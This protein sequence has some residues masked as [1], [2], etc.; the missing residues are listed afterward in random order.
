[1]E[2]DELIKQCKRFFNC[3]TIFDCQDLLN[4][5]IEFFFQAVL[6]HHDENVYSRENADAKILIQMMMTKALHLKNVL[7]GVDYVSQDGRVLNNIIDP[8]IVASLIRNVYET[9]GMFNL[10]YRNTSNKDEKHIL[11]LLWVHAGL[12]YRQL[13]DEIITTEENRKKS[14]DEKK[15]MESIQAEIEKKPLFMKLDDKNKGK[16]KTKIKKRDYLLRFENE[17]V[18]FLNWREL[19]KTMEIKNGKLDHAYAYFSLYSHPSNVSVFQFANMF[20]KNKESYPHLVTYNLQIAFFMFSVFIADYINLFPTVLKTY[21][22]MGL[23][24]QIVINY[25][26]SFARGDEYDINDS[27]KATQ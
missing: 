13:F 22:E 9:T 7:N 2:R 17:Q 12:S 20:E 26:N 4:I 8:T 11:Y 5:Y 15:Y 6:K 18:V 19:T 10:I 27:W 3:E 16:I 1:M 14:E 21:E 25:H 24:E 23:V